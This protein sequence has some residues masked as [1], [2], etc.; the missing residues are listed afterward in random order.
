MNVKDGA[1]EI[2]RETFTKEVIPAWEEE[3]KW[4]TGRRCA[5]RREE[6]AGA[7]SLAN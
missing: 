4:D 6:K 5:L 2:S 3:R 1:S 7:G